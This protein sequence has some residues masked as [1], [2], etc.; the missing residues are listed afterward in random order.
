MAKLKPDA[1]TETDLREFVAN[2]SDF[3]FEMQVLKQLRSL[4]FECSHSGTYQDP[5]SEKI[6]QFDIRA[7]KRK[8][9]CALELGVECKNL[10]ANYPL[11][12]SAVPRTTMESF[13]QLVSFEGAVTQVVNVRTVQAPGSVYKAGEMVGK[14]TDQVGRDASGELLRDDTATFEKLN[15]AVNSCN[16]LVR[17]SAVEPHEPRPFFKAV[18]PVLVVP[19]QLLWQVDYAE[20]GDVLVQPRRVIRSSLFINHAWTVDLGPWGTVEYRL[21]HLEVLTLDGL[22]GILLD[23]LG[24]SGFFAEYKRW[25][26]G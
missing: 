17:K 23:W 18:V 10:R 21:S 15:Q 20:D 6:R 16:D 2:D 19:P 1:I 5:V 14:K 22:P 25:L 26:G 9:S 3:G 11:L 8:G 4:D 13:H 12:L 7:L 24:P